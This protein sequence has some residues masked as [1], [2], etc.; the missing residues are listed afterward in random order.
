MLCDLFDGVSLLHITVKHT[1]DQ[2]D[3]LVTERVRDSQV[4]V[5]N[6]VNAVKRVLL[7]DDGIQEDSKSP[8]VLLL[9]AVRLAGEHLGSSVICSIVSIEIHD[10]EERKVYR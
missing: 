6:L 4:A 7:V 9:A 5:H 2:I 8:D 10:L 1:P 3:A